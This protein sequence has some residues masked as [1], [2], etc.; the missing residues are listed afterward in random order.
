[1]RG[2]LEL[3]VVGIEWR[4]FWLETLASTDLDD[5]LLNFASLVDGR[6]GHDLP[7]VEDGLGE[8]L[9]TSLRAELSVE[10]ERLG[11]G[12]ISLDGEHGRTS[13]LLF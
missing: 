10:T 13:A 2:H 4:N 11:D 1:M 7:V 9:P 6:A 3:V 12:E 8:G 5:Q